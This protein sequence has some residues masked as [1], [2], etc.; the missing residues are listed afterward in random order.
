[1]KKYIFLIYFLIF[2]GTISYIYLMWTN[3][4]IRIKALEEH[5]Y[6]DIHRYSRLRIRIRPDTG[7]SGSGIPG[8]G[9]Y[10]WKLRLKSILNWALL[11][12][13]ID[14]SDS[15][16]LIL[17]MLT[18]ILKNRRWILLVKI[19]DPDFRFFGGSNLDSVFLKG[20]ILLFSL[21]GR[22]WIRFFFSR[23]SDPN[24]VKTHPDPQPW[25]YSL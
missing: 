17:I 7:V 9:L 2:S 1:M 6:Q 22:A 13:F 5:I 18:F 12:V 23:R 14:N 20:R 11:T 19:E 16:I 3:Y 4:W 15:T 8:F 10:T 24:L 25:I 21:K